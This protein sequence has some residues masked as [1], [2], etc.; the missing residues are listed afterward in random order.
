MKPIL[1]SAVSSR[2]LKTFFDEFDFIEDS[3]HIKRYIAFIKEATFCYQNIIHKLYNV[4]EDE[5]IGFVVLGTTKAVDDITG[6]LIEFLYL[7]PQYRG[8]TNEITDIK[9]SHFLLDY[10]IETAIKI[11]KEIAINHIYLV[12]IND[13]VRTIYTKYGFEN[14][15]NSGNNGFEDYMVFN[16]LEEDFTIL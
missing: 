4:K 12:P 2:E 8:K 14:I 13:K 1:I 15:P 11:Q 10:V 3:E 16:L 6:I 9:Y 7:K 5:V